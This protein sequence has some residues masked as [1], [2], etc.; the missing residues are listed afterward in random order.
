MIVVYGC[1]DPNEN[2]AEPKKPCKCEQHDF[3]DSIPSFSE[4]D[5]NSCMS[6]LKKY[7]T[8]VG[9]QVPRYPFLDD[10]WN[11]RVKVSGWVTD[12]EYSVG[13]FIADDTVFTYPD[14]PV[15]DNSFLF[16][17]HVLVL[18][19]W[20]NYRTLENHDGT[21]IKKHF[22]DHY[23][24][25]KKCHFNGLLGFVDMMPVGN[26]CWFFPTICITDT[27]DYYFE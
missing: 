4:T 8:I 3:G 25:S 9:C 24:P 15:L 20:Q 21:E 6:I 22:I 16:F 10:A 19:S 5:Y 12:A 23:V 18:F 17:D 1:K 11:K 14:Y 26:C 27:T 13:Y 2:P 7:T